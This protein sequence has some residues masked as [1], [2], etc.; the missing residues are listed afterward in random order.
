MASSFDLSKASD[1]RL[2]PPCPPWPPCPI[3]R[4]P[5]G[6]PGPIGPAG[7]MGP[8]GAPGSLNGTAACFV[9][10]QLAHLLEQLIAYYPGLEIHLFSM[11]NTPWELVGVPQKV[12][13]STEGT[14]G[15]LFIMKREGIED[16]AVPINKIALLQFKNGAVAYNPAITYLPKPDFPPGCDKNILT[17]IYEFVP[18]L[19]KDIGLIIF[20]IGTKL[21]L[22]CSVN[23]IYLNQYG[24][25]V[26]AGKYGNNPSF[27]PVTY[28]TSIGFLAL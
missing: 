26:L 18:T 14:Y 27:I 10:A 24:L 8:L 9:Y 6:P 22:Y 1:G 17:A 19:P 12:Y 7:L 15:G 2:F 23:S 13:V 3:P 16:I 20:D 4:G 11:G 28:M 5:A 21:K 25:I